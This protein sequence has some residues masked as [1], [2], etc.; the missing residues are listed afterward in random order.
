[1]HVY[2]LMALLVAS[3]L[4]MKV[5]APQNEGPIVD[6]SVATQ[7]EDYPYAIGK[8]ATL[9]TELLSHGFKGKDV[10]QILA[11]SKPYY[12]LSRLP[13]GLR[14][15][16]LYSNNPVLSW[17]GIEFQLSKSKSLLFTLDSQTQWK[18]KL[19]EQ[20][21]EVRL[22]HFV[23]SVR[24]SLWE[25]ARLAKMSPQ[26]IAQLT[27]IFS[28][29][30]DFSRQVTENDS[31]RLSVEQFI[32][33]G[34]LAGW[35]RILAAEYKNNLTN[36]NA[37]Y[38]EKPGKL[39]GYF[40]ADGKSLS[41]SFLRAPIEFARISSGFSLRRFHPK[42]KIFRP[43]LGVDYAAPTGTPIR[44]LGDGKVVEANYS[45]SGGKT[46][47][48]THGSAY[49]TR[50][51]HMNGFAPKI[52]AGTTVKQ[53]QVIGYV[54]TTGLSTGPHLHFEFYLNNRYVDPLKIEMP[55]NESIPKELWAD[56]SAKSAQRL[57]ELPPLPRA[58]ASN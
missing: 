45:P 5:Q 32:V 15:R 52:R 3:F 1:M 58:V 48:L 9:S 40:D 23:G 57:S 31:W 18:V 56:F 7:N 54:G 17:G 33:N 50:Y 53:G 51:L 4:C 42:L 43:H 37:F 6:I 46:I 38:Y 55:A 11:I 29:E 16:L 21:V 2:S 36:Y 24:S 25:S 39:S 27:E 44:A 13:Q 14:Y 49:K 20:K 12:N 8:N 26:L 30:L 22:V 34:K 47:V 35:G 28:W 19:N 41:K 10:H